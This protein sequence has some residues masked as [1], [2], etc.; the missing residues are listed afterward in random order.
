MI[1][2]FFFGPLVV[3]AEILNDLTQSLQSS[4]FHNF[5]DSETGSFQFIFV[6][7]YLSWTK[8]PGNH[9]HKV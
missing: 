6:A 8:P 4:R 9:I 3:L 2:I 1:A 5:Q 7:P